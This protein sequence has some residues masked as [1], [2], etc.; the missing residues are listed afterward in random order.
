MRVALAAALA[1]LV[2]A[3][4]AQAKGKVPAS[5]FGVSATLP[6]DHDFTRMGTSGFGAYRFDI[7]WAGVQKTRQGGYNWAGIDPTVSQVANAGMQPTPLLLGTPRFVKKSPDGLYP[8]TGEKEDLEAWKGFVA[9]ATKRYGPGG[10]FWAENPSVPAKPIHTW[11]VWNEQNARAFWRPKPDPRDYAKLV[12][13]SD[14]EISAVDPNAKIVLGGMF[15][16]PRDERSFSAVSFLKRFYRARG[17]K[18]HFEAI[19]VHPYG[20]G[21]GTVKTQI[22]EARAAA[23]KAGDRNVGILIGE[24][25]WASKGPK[26]TPEVVGERGQASRLRKGLE[27]LV[28]KHRSWNILGAYVYVWR[29]FAPELTPCL[30]CPGAG[31]VTVNDKNKPALSTVR[32]V[33]RSSR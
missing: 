33:I 5:F 22:K 26:G 29:D 4:A 15:G 2:L 17:I 9:A 23:R 1:V 19:G 10:D 11:L 7:N 6:S 3:P 24:I 16:Y 20:A 14:E 13:A 30:W 18:K 27:L 28:N 32:G 25:G 21:V 12:R 31:L 8:P